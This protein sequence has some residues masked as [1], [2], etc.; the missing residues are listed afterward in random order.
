MSRRRSG[1]RNPRAHTCGGD[2]PRD[3]WRHGG[4]TSSPGI[5]EREVEW[6]DYGAS[7]AFFG[8]ANPSCARCGGRL[9]G[10]KLCRCEDPDWRI[11]G[12]RVVLP[13]DAP[14]EGEMPGRR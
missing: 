12:E 13:A 11:R 4:G 9:R 6:P 7:S 5:G 10:E 2:D 1:I 8:A 14:A 3:R